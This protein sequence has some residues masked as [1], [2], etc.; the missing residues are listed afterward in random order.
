MAEKIYKRL[1]RE[2]EDIT[3]NPILGAEI[4]VIGDDITKWHVIIDGP[5]DSPYAGGK[6]VIS[7][8]FSS[9][10]YPFKCPYI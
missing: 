9:D 7:I 6:F 10:N 5:P 1:S 3:K 4:K 2:L 8:D